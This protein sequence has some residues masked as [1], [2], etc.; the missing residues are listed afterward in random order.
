MPLLSQ[1]YGICIYMFW[2][3]HNPPHF[4]AE[5]ADNSILVSI[6]DGVVI[7]GVFPIKQL[8]LVLAWSELHKSELLEN[9]RMAEEHKQLVSISPLV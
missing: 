9:W 7:K 3:E 8:K 4:H 1:F 2:Q 6:L 5:Y